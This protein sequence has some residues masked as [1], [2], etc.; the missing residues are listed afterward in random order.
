MIMQGCVIS[1]LTIVFFQKSR[2]L[3]RSLLTNNNFYC[4]ITGILIVSIYRAETYGLPC[5]RKLF[6]FDLKK[7][8][9]ASF[10]HENSNFCQTHL[11]ASF[12]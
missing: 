3:S 10:Y 11:Q 2:N 7:I 5:S 9:T 6:I 8:I 4:D 1:C 12:V